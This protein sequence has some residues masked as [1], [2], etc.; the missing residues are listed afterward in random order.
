MKRVLI[1]LLAAVAC[2]LC[3][4][5]EIEKIDKFPTGYINGTYMN[6]Y[7][8]ID[9]V[10]YAVGYESDSNWILVRYPAGCRNTTYTVH[11]NCRRVARGAFQG[12]AYLKLIYLP[13]TV[14]YIGE[15][16]FEGCSSLQGI[17]FGDGSPT[18]VKDL[19]VTENED[20]SDVVARY[21]LTGKP[22]S[23]NDKGVQIQVY[24]DYSAKAIVV[25]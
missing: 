7:K 3:E 2:M 13:E 12:A 21:D 10:L 23:P 8:S 15:D 25:K 17:E 14:S 16:A 5:Q 6:K 11:P 22:C 18:A 9:G 19:G 20:E 24:S 1:I 4:A